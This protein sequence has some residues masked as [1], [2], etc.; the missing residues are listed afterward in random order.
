[1]PKKVKKLRSLDINFKNFAFKN[2][3]INNY[4]ILFKKVEKIILSSFNLIIIKGPRKKTNQPCLPPL[5]K[6]NKAIEFFF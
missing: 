3:V 5:K 4:C 6:K 1:M 2:D